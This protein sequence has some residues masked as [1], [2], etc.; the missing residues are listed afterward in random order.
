MI[1]FK[2][3]KAAILE[4]LNKPLAIREIDLPK[5]LYRGQVLVKMKYSGICGSQIGEIQGIKGKDKFL[6]HLLGHEGFWTVLKIGSGVKNIKINDFV[7]LHWKIGKGIDAINAKYQYKNKII[8]SGKVTTFSNLTVVSENRLTPINKKKLLKPEIMPLFGCALT[9]GFGVVNNLCNDLKNKNIIIYGA[10][11]I[12]LSILKACL[13]KNPK[14]II[15]ID[16]TKSKLNLSKKLGASHVIKSNTKNLKYLI[17]KICS[18]QGIDVFFDNTGNTKVIET[19]YHLTNSRGQII[20]IGVPKIFSKISINTLP[21]HFGKTIIGTHGG[22]INPS[23]DIKKLINL[24]LKKK[25]KFDSIVTN[26]FPF[27][28]INH[29]INLMK[30][31]KIDGRCIIRF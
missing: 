30:K 3:T 16:K 2:K 27:E 12:G 20:L 22:E 18:N 9:T 14:K 13:L 15:V 4:E 31:G 24:Q 1:E 23:K 21:L 29:A 17:N 7:V 28:K 8:N 10:G 26:I 19:G 5:K 6:P 11:G 25:V